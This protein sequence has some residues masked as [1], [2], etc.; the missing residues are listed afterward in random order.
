MV[1]VGRAVSI[2]KGCFIDALSTEGILFGDNV[3]MGKNVRIECTGS[4]K[5]LGKGILVG[6]NVGLGADCF[7]G[8]A[9]G[10]TIGDDTIMGNYVSFHAENH[11]IDDTEKL[12]RLQGYSHQGINV[13]NNC[14]IGS[15]A[16]LLDG[17]V[18]EDGCIIAAGAVVIAGH[19][20]RNGI[21]GGVPAKL[22]RYRGTNTQ[23]EYAEFMKEPGNLGRF[24]TS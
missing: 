3:S 15:K 8:C 22:I 23:T 13:G 4:L 7:F 17:A 16:T 10:I 2:G 24:K 14:W 12:I 5:Q 1:R 18:I 19:Y 21:Y 6:N 9:G 11:L 20:Q